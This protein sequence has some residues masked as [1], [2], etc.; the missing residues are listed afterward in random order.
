MVTYK[1]PDGTSF[2]GTIDNLKLVA[3]I[4]VKTI[5]NN[6]IIVPKG[7]YL[8]SYQKLILIKDM[9]TIHIK[10]TI[11]KKIT[12]FNKTVSHLSDSNLETL[13][14]NWIQN[15][16]VIQDLFEELKSRGESL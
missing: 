1:W 6:N 3:G 2:T 7:W 14:L 10:N 12:N 4:L 16:Q 11:K 9:N 5:D 8:S 13:Y 15:N